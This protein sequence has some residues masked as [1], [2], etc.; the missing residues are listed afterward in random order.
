M[1]VIKRLAVFCGSSLG[2]DPLYA[3]VTRQLAT[4]LVARNIELVY[5]GGNV[6][7]MRVVADEV[8]A[9]GGRVLGVMPQFL[10]E[11]EIAHHA[12]TEL[13]MVDTMHARKSTIAALADGFILLPGGFGS[14]EEFIEM[15]TWRQLALHNK[16]CAILNVG[17]YFDKLLSFIQHATEQRFVRSVHHELII[18][19]EQPQVLLTA[20][21]QQ[22]PPPVIDK[23][24]TALEEADL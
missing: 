14:V 2:A 11:K 23:W 1:G 15:C 17:H 16:P 10:V 20:M 22:R 8:L 19:E 5:G 3:E 13:I 12:L 24:E 21:T 7:I 9:Q 18:V 4:E 6:G